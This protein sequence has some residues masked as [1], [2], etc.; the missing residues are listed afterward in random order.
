ML[1][2]K[3]IVVCL[4]IDVAVLGIIAPIAG[5]QVRA[6]NRIR[7]NVELV[8]I[9]VVVFDDKGALAANLKKSDFRILEDGIEQR[10]LSCERER[11]PVSFVILA[12]I[13]SSMTGK[14]AFVQ[15]AA[16]SLVEPPEDREQRESI[17][18]F[19]VLGVETRVK[20]LVPFTND[21]K[22][23]ERRLPLLL[24][25]TN[26]STALFDAIYYG[27]TSARRD[28]ANEQRAIILISDGGD[29]HSRYRL[30]ETK[31]VLEEADVPV[32]AVM[33]GPSF[34]LPPFLLPQQKR[35]KPSKGGIPGVQLPYADVDYIGPAERR[36]PHNLKT[37]TEASG[38][39][40]FTAR[41][42]ED[43]PRIVQTI[44]QAVRY[45]YVLTYTPDR[46][47]ELVGARDKADQDPARHKIHLELVPKEKFKGY[48][49]P[50]YKPS[51]RSI[52]YGES[53]V[54]GPRS[55]D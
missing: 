16:L 37:L 52:P 29:N 53:S 9:P 46:P 19:S 18:E 41:Q 17:D 45:R 50:Y 28:A 31:R 54:V 34:E 21:K 35:S 47:Q 12:D 2:Y 11:V 38:G 26:G 44:G 24:E 33:A 36:G 25:P 39:G 22:D 5:A 3:A 49:L 42:L 23:L 20:L 7:S 1:R 48:F 10:I 4:A 14:I 43:L 55:S 30:V 6:K 27:V 8:Q 51:Y 32:F 13:S 40:V 15:E